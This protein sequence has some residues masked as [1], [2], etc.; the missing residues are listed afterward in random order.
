MNTSDSDLTKQADI[1]AFNA[2]NKPDAPQRLVL[3][4]NKGTEGW[5][6]PSLFACALARK[7]AHVE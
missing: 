6:C 7:F 2:L 1:D 4:V 5:N 3:L